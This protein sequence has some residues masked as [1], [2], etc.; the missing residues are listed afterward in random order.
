MQDISVIILT[1][2]EE[3]HI[4][5]AVESAKRLAKDVFVVDSFSTD[6]TVE[7]AK[8]MGAV[9]YQHEFTY[10]A[11]Q[12]NWAIENL[13]IRTEWVFRLDADEYLT[14][15]LIDEIERVLPNT[16]ADVTGYTAVRLMTFMGKRIKHG[17]LPMIILRLWRNGMAKCEDKKMDEHMRVIEGTVGTLQGAF[18]D[19]SKITLTEWTQK[20][21]KYSTHEAL[22][23]LCTKYNIG[24]VDNDAND[25][26][27]AHSAQKRANKLKYIKLPLFWRA[28]AFFCYRYLLR[29]GFLDGKEGFLWH[30]LQGFWYRALAD[31]KV[32]EIKKRFG[33]DDERIKEYLSKATG[34]E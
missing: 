31:A 26:I 14:D 12:V 15:E 20:H 3:R 34:C 8:S 10:H 18:V 27:G 17:I 13:P 23:L 24:S 16:P 4:Q 11:A 32:Y 7:I 2:N 28:F 1:F 33:F 9:V 29:G 25:A 22:D 30:F 6:K 19:D 5:R 21:N